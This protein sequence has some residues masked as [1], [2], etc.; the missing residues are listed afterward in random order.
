[1]SD[2]RPGKRFTFEA[3]SAGD[4][5]RRDDR[6]ALFT[7]AD[8]APGERYSLEA[9]HHPLEEPTETPVDSA[10]DRA[11]AHPRK[12]HR[13]LLTV[14]L[15]TLIVGGVQAFETLSNAWLGGDLLAGAWSVLGLGVITL[16]ASALGREL[17]KLR[18][19]RRHARLRERVEARLDDDSLDGRKMH[20]LCDRLRQQMGLS[21]R[22]PHWQDFKKAHQQHHDATET[23][24]LF[25][26]YVLAPRDARAR[27][28]ITR[29]SGETAMLVA[30]SPLTITDM[31][32]MAWRNLR[33]ID[34]LADLYGLELG[35][36]SRLTLFRTVLAN[37]AFAGASEI[38]TEASM[39]L[40]SMNLAGKLSSRAGQGL[41]SGLLTAR[42][43]IRALKMLRPLPFEDERAP[44]ISDL[45][46]QLW[47]QMKRVDEGKRDT[48]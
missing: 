46:R 35:Y 9:V 45:R 26:H 47:Q 21:D 32:L 29:M 19:L 34:R 23:R 44:K 39:D 40:L 12:R 41:A 16:A 13:G 18:R 2:P 1:M 25:A 20:A 5:H 10:L 11:L 14:L 27:A 42:L 4:A 48:P 6:E 15:G 24:A 38:A 28:L 37:M 17:L 43:G 33:M 31:G 22:D 30:I 3:G 8:P 7:P 36:A